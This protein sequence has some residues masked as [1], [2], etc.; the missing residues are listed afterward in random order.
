M[1][2]YNGWSNYETWLL[3]L[4]IDNEFADYTYWRGETE[5]IARG[6]GT[7]RELADMLKDSFEEAQPKLE[8]FWL[9]MLN[10]AMSEVNWQEIAENML[11]EFIEQESA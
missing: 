5:A 8:G 10:A 1:T 3:K 4:W 7:A 9:D 2:D 6:K 11:N